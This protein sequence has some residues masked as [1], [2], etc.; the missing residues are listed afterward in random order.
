MKTAFVLSGGGAA[1]SYQL[2][3]LKA[4]YEQGIKPDF[5]T[6]NSAGSLNAAGLSC[7]GIE[8]LEKVWLDITKRQ[9]IFGDKFLG[10]A[11]ALWSNSIWNSKPLEKLIKDIIEN[12]DPKIP[13]WVN[14]VD[15]R[16]GALMRVGSDQV[17]HHTLAKFVL[18]SASL[19]VLTPPVDGHLVDGGVRENTPLK[20]AID[21]GAERIFVFLNSPKGHPMTP[22]YKFDKVKD[23]AARA[24]SIMSDEAHWND[25]ATAEFYNTEGI[26]RKIE[27]KYFAPS[28]RKIDTLDFEP[29]KIRAAIRQGYEETKNSLMKG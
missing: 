14:T 21:L 24:L 25:I 15:L 12:N 22:M 6:A 16:S 19:P 26:G 3:C 13:F 7:L 28:I 17:T 4:V 2:G 9:D 10:F 23:V 18:A 1:G 5:I 8:G 29:Q 27:L 20:Q 11:Q